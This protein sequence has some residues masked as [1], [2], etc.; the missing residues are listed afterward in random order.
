MRFKIGILLAALLFGGSAFAGEPAQDDGAV[1][2]IQETVITA[3]EIDE[4]AGATLEELDLE[5]IQFEANL[6]KRRHDI[7]RQALNEL[8]ARELISREAEAL[9]VA[10]DDLI[11]TEIR[12]QVASPTDAEIEQFYASR[13]AQLQQ[14]GSLEQLTPQ[15][16]NFLQQQQTRNRFDEYIGGLKEKYGVTV[17][18]EPLRFA[19]AVEGFPSRGPAE[20]PVTIVEFSD[21]E[22]PYCAQLVGTLER[23][24]ADFPE[25]VRLVFRQF[26]LNNIHRNAQKAAEASLCASEQGKFWEMHDLLFKN[27][28]RL[29]KNHLLEYAGTAEL[30][31]DEFHACLDADRHAASVVEDIKA[32]VA[33]GVGGTPA[34]FVNGR[35]LA[36]AATFDDIVLLVREELKSNDTSAEE[37]EGSGR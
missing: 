33:A 36:G 30:D 7:R 25:S 4:L 10:E 21:F 34:L 1:A 9:G 32:G 11:E 5:R 6:K 26:P 13:R 27:Q 35:P 3:A 23:V 37:A 16:R 22:C 29:E 20:A 17:E 8:I 28:G 18:M 15:I 2:R 12:S 31:V 14:Q 19:V 24:R